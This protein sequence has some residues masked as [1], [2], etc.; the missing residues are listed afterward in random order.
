MWKLPKS[1]YL[2]SFNARSIKDGLIFLEKNNP[3]DYKQ[4]KIAEQ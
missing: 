2:S 1:Y 4:R 3:L